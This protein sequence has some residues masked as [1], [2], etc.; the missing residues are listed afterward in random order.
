MHYESR[1]ASANMVVNW[2]VTEACNYRCAYC[3]AHWD[4]PEGNEIIRNPQTTEDLLRS[5]HQGFAQ[6]LNR[7]RLN[8]AG[9]EPLLFTK[10][11]LRAM[12]LAADLGFEVSLI[13]NGSRLTPS[14][15][16][17]MTPL[18]KVLGISLDTGTDH[19]NLEIGRADSRGNSSPV[20]ALPE[21]I[22]LAR[23][24][25]PSLIQDQHGCER[26]QTG[27]WICPKCWNGSRPS[28]GRS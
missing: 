10:Q 16:R 21:M 11:V 27:V 3:Y 9:G 28:N 5:L 19:A 1:P 22:A 23:S 13:T 6:G 17:A 25:N 15:L 12:R 4:R 8:F 18:L 20:S 26:R 7:V 2:H 14:T 24:L